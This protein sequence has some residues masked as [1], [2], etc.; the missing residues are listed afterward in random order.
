MKNK[1]KTLPTDNSAHLLELR[2]RA[3]KVLSELGSTS[4]SMDS[5]D[6][7]RLLEEISV[8]HIELELQNEELQKTRN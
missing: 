3:N 6:Q 1:T 2:E 8:Y 5:F 7:Q 4:L